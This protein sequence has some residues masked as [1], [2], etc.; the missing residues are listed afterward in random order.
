MRARHIGSIWLIG[1]FIVLWAGCGD[2]QTCVRNG[3]DAPTHIP[4]ACDHDVDCRAGFCNRGWCKDEGGTYGRS[5]NLSAPPMPLGAKQPRNMCDGYLCLDG[6]CRA[7]RSDA[8]CQSYFGAGHCMVVQDPLGR[9]RGAA[10]FPNTAQFAEGGSCTRDADCLSSFCDRGI[11]ADA[12]D[13]GAWNYGGS[14]CK[15]GPPHAPE[16]N[17]VTSAGFDVCAGYVCVDQRC[18]SCTSDAECQAGSSVYKCMAYFE[19]PGKRCG[20]PNE[21]LR[22]PGA[23]RPNLHPELHNDPREMVPSIA[24]TQDVD[25]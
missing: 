10:C 2:H 8:D 25:R 22:N 1:G 16:D 12:L 4:G 20:D 9:D 15:P 17:V 24:P 13:I 11:C 19:L 6:R 18:R 5:C 14:P 3:P 7:C 21:Y 23:P